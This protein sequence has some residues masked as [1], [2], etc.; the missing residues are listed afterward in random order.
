MK[1]ILVLLTTIILFGCQKTNNTPYSYE[2]STIY[3]NDN[4]QIFSN[5]VLSIQPY[6]IVSGNKKYITNQKITNITLTINEDD[7]GYNNSFAI[8][9]S[10]IAN[11][12]IYNNYIVSDNELVYDA[13]IPFIR[14]ANNTVTAQDYSSLLN[15]YI[16]LRN[17]FYSCR[18]SSFEIML[19][20]NTIKKIKTNQS[21]IIEVTGNT[22]SCFMGIIEVLIN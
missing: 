17:G 22:T 20:N 3:S 7:F 14:P 9:T 8:D 4:K 5:I 1:K 18:L 15:N 10:I 21:K 11:K 13:V 2:E 6:I 12:Q 16:I 19:S